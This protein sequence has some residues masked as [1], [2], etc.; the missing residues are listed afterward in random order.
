[1][2]YRNY[3]INSMQYNVV[4]NDILTSLLRRSNEITNV[5][6]SMMKQQI[7]KNKNAKIKS[8]HTLVRVV[9]IMSFVTIDS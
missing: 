7:I 4:E 3:A 8:L 9:K 5:G 2:I 6:V 1:M